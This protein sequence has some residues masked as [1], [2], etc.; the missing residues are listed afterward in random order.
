MISGLADATVIVEARARSSALIT[1][2]WSLE[3]GRDC[4]VVLGP[5]DAAQSVGCNPLLRL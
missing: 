4:F 3:Q 5:I 1:A 2:S